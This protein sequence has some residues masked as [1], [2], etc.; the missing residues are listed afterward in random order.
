MKRTP[1]PESNDTKWR[2]KRAGRPEL[3]RLQEKAAG[4][5][6]RPWCISQAG[7]TP[8]ATTWA[9]EEAVLVSDAADLLALQRLA[10]M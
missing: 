4:L 2:Q 7:F 3:E 8:D 6:A 10:R 1:T 5:Q 9:S